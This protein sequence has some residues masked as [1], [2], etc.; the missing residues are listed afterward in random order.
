MKKLLFIFLFFYSIIANSQS[1]LT[2]INKADE[3]YKSE[4]FAQALFIYKNLDAPDDKISK[5][6]DEIEGKLLDTDFANDQFQK[7][8]LNGNS[9]LK[10]S[11][12]ELAYIC[13][14]AALLIKPD[15]NFP[16]TK[17]RDLSKFVSD[18][19]V[20][21]RFNKLIADAD[22][23]YDNQDYERAKSVY[24]EALV[25]NPNDTHASNRIV[26]IDELILKKN[27]VKKEYDDNIFYAD[28]FFANGDIDQA[29]EYYQKALDLLPNESY[30]KQKIN[31]ILKL[32]TDAMALEEAYN[33]AINDGDSAFNAQSYEL[34]IE[35]FTE[36]LT[37]KP[38]SEYPQSMI[39]KS[40]HIL[41][42][43]NSKENEIA[44]IMTSVDE[45][46]AANQYITAQSQIQKGLSLL[47]NDSALIAKKSFV[48]SVIAQQQV[49]DI[50]FDNFV[51]MA[52]E[53]FS[54]KDYETASRYYS[55][56]LEIKNNEDILKKL[57]VSD[58]LLSIQ[59]AKDSPTEPTQQDSSLADN[60]D[61]TDNDKPQDNKEVAKPT[62]EQ[63]AEN[64]LAGE[65][66]PQPKTEPENKDVAENKDET[67]PVNNSNDGALS[68][69]MQDRLDMAGQSEAYKKMMAESKLLFDKKLYD[70]ALSSFEEILEISPNDPAVMQYINDINSIFAENVAVKLVTAPTSIAAGAKQSFDYTRILPKDK[71]NC[72]LKVVIHKTDETTPKAYV[73][74]YKI[75]A[76]KSGFV[77]KDINALSESKPIYVRLSDIPA[78]MRED[79]NRIEIISEAGTISID[80]MSIIVVM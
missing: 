55:K 3:M 6:I 8:I 76:K 33:K 22:N 64:K 37:I 53:A 71:R 61:K 31:D 63:L 78:W 11:E 5:R 19:N 80:E 44:A 59:K 51:S 56:A 38:N 10:S 42:Q 50:N 77:I 14:N 17:L 35:L 41:E 32:Q 48:D 79:I 72:Y 16:K 29:K 13:F 20:D 58:S 39:N 43:V 24:R 57:S 21:K 7:C 45:Y 73:N 40:N 26:E 75:N 62:D 36:A 25:V 69:E 30:P 34:A 4:N 18:P 52:S 65:D 67:A 23:Y 74:F 28:R 9:A 60:D 27:S 1:L 46:I 70:K 68:Q 66:V 12:H 15:A 54:D 47:P 49:N 2:D